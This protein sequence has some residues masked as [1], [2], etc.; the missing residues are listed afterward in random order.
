MLVEK[1]LVWAKTVSETC[2]ER[3]TKAMRQLR[4]KQ[5]QG[6]H[7]LFINHSGEGKIT[8]LLVYVDN[9]IITKNDDIE[10]LAL[11]EHLA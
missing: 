10:K 2:F 5:S 6:D 9:I 4:Y 11:K 3:F 8:T 1:G 7:I